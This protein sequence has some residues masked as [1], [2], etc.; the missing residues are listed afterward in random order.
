M[1]NYRYL[2]G[3]LFISGCGL[4]KNT[5]TSTQNSQLLLKQKA[6]LRLTAHRDWL[7]DSA[8][9]T[10]YQDSANQNYSI[11]LWPKGAFTYSA[12]AGFSGE[13]DRILI[14]GEGKQWHTDTRLQAIREADK[15]KL[16]LKLKQQ[17]KLSIE[18]ND[19]VIKSSV[20]WKWV[21]MVSILTILLGLLCFKIF[22]KFTLKF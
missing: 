15:G 19:K 1:K 16:S 7:K 20:S 3:V 21:L 4:L 6:D 8:S 17:E 5:S 14:T 13:A 12:A 18:K 9:F 2:L 10:F 11:Q 22:K